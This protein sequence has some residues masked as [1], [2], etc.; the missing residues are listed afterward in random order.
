MEKLKPLVAF[1]NA[2]G[3]PEELEHFLSLFKRADAIR[4]PPDKG[5]FSI[6]DLPEDIQET[7]DNVAKET[8]RKKSDI[9][10][11]LINLGSKASRQPE[12]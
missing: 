7:V 4:F 6:V 8:G 11:E 9:I 2:F 10:N 5:E 3:E 1:M 12:S